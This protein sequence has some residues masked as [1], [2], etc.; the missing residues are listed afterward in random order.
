MDARTSTTT[1]DTALALKLL[2]EV[3]QTSAHI[4]ALSDLIVEHEGCSKRD[5]PLALTHAI[6]TLAQR[7]GWLAD[8]ASVRLGDNY[9]ARG[10]DA[11]DWFMPPGITP[12]AVGG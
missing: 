11:N 5:V 6:T 9:G 4:T 7:A 3:A 12:T 8:L 1:P 10:P 2:H